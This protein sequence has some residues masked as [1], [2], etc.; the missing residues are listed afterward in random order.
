MK[1]STEIKGLEKFRD[2]M[3]AEGYLEENNY[4]RSEL[5]FDNNFNGEVDLLERGAVQNGE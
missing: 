1:F 3:T 4:Q 5:I 2:F